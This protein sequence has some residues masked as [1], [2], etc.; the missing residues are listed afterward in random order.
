MSLIRVHPDPSRRQLAVFAAAWAVFF[1][2]AGTGILARGGSAA[3]AGVVWATAAALPAIGW[4]SPRLLRMA[5]LGTAW[6]AFPIGF[7]VSYLI[8]AAVYYLVLT[9][10]G[11]LMRALGHDPLGRRFDAGAESYWTPRKAEGSLKRYFRQF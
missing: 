2:A 5:Y 9:P 3:L 11:L 6:L 8:L 4:L 10:T 7:V 1:A